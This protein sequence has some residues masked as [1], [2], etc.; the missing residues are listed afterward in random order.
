MKIRNR[1]DFYISPEDIRYS[2][3]RLAYCP[4]TNTIYHHDGCLNN[5]KCDLLDASYYEEI[6][7]EEQLNW[8]LKYKDLEHL[9]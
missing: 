4:F 8:Y 2:F 9:K 5:N 1:N 3:D 6:K 7:T